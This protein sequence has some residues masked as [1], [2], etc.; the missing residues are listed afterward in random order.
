MMG[1]L[2]LDTL[3]Q[4]DAKYKGGK[5]LKNLCEELQTKG[6]AQP[7]CIEPGNYFPSPSSSPARNLIYIRARAEPSSEIPPAFEAEPSLARILN[8]FP[9]RAE[10]AKLGLFGSSWLE[11]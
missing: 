7:G 5:M 3:R 9:S 6:W 1:D 8:W 11:L 2:N 10:P 4:K